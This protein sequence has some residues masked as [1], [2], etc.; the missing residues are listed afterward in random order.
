MVGTFADELR[1]ARVDGR[2][3]VKQASEHLPRVQ[4]I[5]GLVFGRW[6]GLVHR[7]S[8]LKAEDPHDS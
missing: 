1:E 5:G 2:E 7:E 8:S 6:A 4:H 3:I